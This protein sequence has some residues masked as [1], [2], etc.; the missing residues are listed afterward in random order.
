MPPGKFGWCL[1]VLGHELQMVLEVSPN[2]V[3]VLMTSGTTG[4]LC[5]GPTPVACV[6]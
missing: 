6:S 5:V 4:V 2:G 3:L 1:S